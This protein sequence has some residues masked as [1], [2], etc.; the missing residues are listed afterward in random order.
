MSV[1]LRSLFAA[2]PTDDL[3]AIRYNIQTYEE[4]KI[5][6]EIAE[7][8]AIWAYIREFAEKHNHAPNSSTI[9][10]HFEKEGLL[11]VTD[12]I[13]MLKTTKPV[14]HG[15]YS[16]IVARQVEQHV[17]KQLSDILREGS[18]I[19]ASGMV[20]K[21]GKE[22][23]TL[24]G[25]KD[26]VNHILVK[27]FDLMLP[28]SGGSGAKIAGEVTTDGEDFL[29]EY[30]KVKNEP[31]SG[32]GY[33]T[34]IAQMDRAISGA[35]RYELWTHAAFTGGLKSTLLLNWAYSQAVHYRNSSLIFSLEMPYNQCRRIL[36]A[37]HSMNDKFLDVRMGLGI[38]TQK[39]IPVGLPYQ[40]IRD[41][42]LHLWHPNA[43]QFF[44]QHVVPDFNSEK[45]EYG[46]IQIEVAD[47][48]KSEF[49]VADIRLKAQLL[50]NKM[51]FGLMFVDHMGLMAPRKWVQSTTDRL[52][53]VI[54]DLKRLAMSF[55]HGEGLAVVGLFQINREGYKAALKTEGKY[56]LTHLSYANE[57]ERSSDIV[58]AGWVDDELKKKGRIRFQCLKSRD[59]APF[60]D[61]FSRVEWPCRR[62]LTMEMLD[63][64]EED[65]E[66]L[67]DQ[68]DSNL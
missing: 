59:Q 12:R 64:S 9:E 19:L 49:T 6:F 22:E 55:N 38:Q 24:K 32:V 52:N 33:F 29:A 27:S 30:E 11:A 50:R 2:L 35:K 63:L 54:R 48:D 34:G 25:S 17:T 20:L 1:M 5:S 26:A 7:D 23:K 57:C 67:G 39:D 58:T 3:E 44:K 18:Q 66:A 60:D 56:N 4:A 31:Q 42:Q 36:Y 16:E 62:L 45:N 37:M 61:F 14:Y 10:S 65:K 53:E 51:D 13:A 43:E 47:P 15:D 68:I 40:N 8:R 41:G 46:K 28:R 21:E